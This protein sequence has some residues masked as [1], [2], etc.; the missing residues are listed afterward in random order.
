VPAQDPRMT[1]IDPADA[2]ELYWEQE[3]Y[4]HD[5]PANK[6]DHTAGPWTLVGSSETVGGRWHARYWLVVADAN[7]DT[8]G[9]RYGIGLTE[10]QEHDLP[11]DGK[12]GPLPL[13]RLYPHE[14]TRVEYHTKAPA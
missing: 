6:G 7:D 11:W 14:V 1:A 4:G 8:W 3:N 9:L 10:N 5:A 12:D 13:V 2:E